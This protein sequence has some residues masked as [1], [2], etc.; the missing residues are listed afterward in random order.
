MANDEKPWACPKCGVTQLPSKVKTV[1]II[2]PGKNPRVE[3]H[4]KIRA[5]FLHG[6]LV[7]SCLVCGHSWG[8]E[9]P[10]PG[11][12]SITFLHPITECDDEC[13]GQCS[14]RDAC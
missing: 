10:T 3:F 9:D 12:A 7:Y 14:D 13:T 5:Y 2:E 8:P 11:G 6:N 1:E 4:G